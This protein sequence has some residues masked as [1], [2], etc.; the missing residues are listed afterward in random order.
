MGLAKD[1]VSGQFDELGLALVQ[2]ARMCGITLDQ[3]NVVERVIRNDA[4]VCTRDN[5]AAFTDLRG[6]LML[7]LKLQG[8]SFELLGPQETMEIADEVRA[9]IRS[10]LGAPPAGGA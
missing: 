4:T 10:H 7:A 5:P 9:R 1:W 3:P 2:K 6:L 8:R